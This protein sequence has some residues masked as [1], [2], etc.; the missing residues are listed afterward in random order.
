MVGCLKG[1][2]LFFLLV[3][4]TST[5]IYHYNFVWVPAPTSKEIS[6]RHVPHCVEFCKQH[7]ANSGDDSFLDKA[8]RLWCYNPEMYKQHWGERRGE[9]CFSST[10]SVF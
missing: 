10:V 5:Y 9:P 7:I 2:S 8:I 4:I 3:A 1:V 6:T